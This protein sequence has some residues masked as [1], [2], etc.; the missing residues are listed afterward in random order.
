MQRKTYRHVYTM[1]NRRRV[2]LFVFRKN[3]DKFQSIS[4]VL[5]I[6]LWRNIFLHFAWLHEQLLHM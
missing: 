2:E 4:T 1:R 5:A 3:W 6:I